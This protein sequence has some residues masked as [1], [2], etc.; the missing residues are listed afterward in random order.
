ME[1]YP[2]QLESENEPKKKPFLKLW[3]C[4]VFLSVVL[5]VG[6]AVF[7]VS[8]P[9]LL[10]KPFADLFFTKDVIKNGLNL[11]SEDIAKLRNN[12]V[13]VKEVVF[14]QVNSLL[15]NKFKDDEA[16]TV[17][18]DEGDIHIEAEYPDKE[19]SSSCSLKLSA[20]HPKINGSLLKSSNISTGLS[21][22]EDGVNAFMEATLDAFINV[23]F[24]FRAEIGAKIFKKCRSVRE[25]LAIKLTTTGKVLIAVKIT[26]TNVRIEAV[27][28]NLEL[29]FDLD[30]ELE[31]KPFD[32]NVDDVDVS[33]CDVKL[34]NKVKIGSYCNLVKGL[35]KEGVQKYLDKWTE[36]KAPKIVKKLEDKLKKKIG[37]EMS[38]PII[39]F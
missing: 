13:G 2:E 17:L 15:R 11:T 38:F 29:K 23:D 19:F 18:I 35:I 25:T 21:L 24:D 28:N 7:L 3:H 37:D 12:D 27:E 6:V 30:F 31:G 26:G 33:K 8:Y 5:I 9:A 4:I 16:V 32:W 10:L 22:D 39:K 36:F 20:L 1:T 14:K 34:G